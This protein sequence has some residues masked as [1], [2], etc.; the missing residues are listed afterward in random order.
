M[1]DRRG[2]SVS[3]Y[4]APLFLAWQ[5]TNRCTARCL[6]CCE[7][8]GPDKA[9]KAELSREEA[10]SLAR[11]AV[12]LSIPYAAFGGGEPLGV[13]HVWEIFD[14]LHA[15]GTR[16]K[17]ETN[18]LLID[19]AAAERLSGY[20]E[21]CVQISLDGASPA[22][23]ESVRPGGDFRGVLCAVDAL[24]RRGIKPELV[25]VPTRRNLA[26]A[27]A[28]YQAAVR[29][30]A[31]A[32]V[33]GPMMR[34]G[35]A[36]EEYELLAP[37]AEEWFLCVSALKALHQKLGEP[38]ALSIYP[39]D[40]AEECRVRLQSPQAMM[41]VVPDGKVKLLNALPF[42]CADLREQS[43]KEA[44]QAYRKAWKHPAVAE[45][46]ARIPK[47]LSLLKHANETW[48]PESWSERAA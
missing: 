45:F 42:A 23:H 17:I 25:F 27:P 8:S 26:D 5:L 36:A 20:A 41:L 11:Q 37:S 6:H 13:P 29:M 3:E 16:L 28:V 9:W 46:I 38:I 21:P 33:T 35:R 39:W 48:P 12:K 15:G 19:D 34:L 14:I 4:E 2:A 44:W 40:I 32:F 7:E 18:G 24:V 43:L 10:L 47:D 30:G 31:R 1:T 22:V